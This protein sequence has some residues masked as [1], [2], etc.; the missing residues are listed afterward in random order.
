MPALHENLRAPKR[1]GF[2]N[3]FV[4]TGEGDDVGVIV[5]LDAVEGAEFAIDV[6]DVGVIDV[7]I[8]DVSGDLVAAAIVSVFLGEL[9][10]VIGE[11]AEFLEGQGPKAPGLRAVDA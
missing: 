3:L 8:D 5:L 10:A 2:G 6:A 7:A 1:E 9:A 11:G 4:Q